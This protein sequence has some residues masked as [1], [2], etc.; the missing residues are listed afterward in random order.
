MFLCL[1]LASSL[2]FSAPDNQSALVF[3]SLFVIFWVG[4][5]VVTVN[6][7]LLGGQISFLQ[8]VCVL[9]YCLAPLSFASLLCHF[10]HLR[11]LHFALVG[12][13][14][15]WAV[16]ASV[17]FMGQLVTEEKRALGTYPILLFFFAIAWLIL[18]E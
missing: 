11:A 7:V 17:G 15:V 13:A 12:V 10:I 3:A 1:F 6:A 16:R 18:L 14:Y 5:A 2:S 9:G 8:A 4:A